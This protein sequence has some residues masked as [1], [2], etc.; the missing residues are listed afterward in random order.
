MS[1]FTGSAANPPKRM[2]RPVIWV[3]AACLLM[4][5]GANFLAAHSIDCWLR[6]NAVPEVPEYPGA[7]FTDGASRGL[8]ERQSPFIGYH[9]V[10]QAE[11]EDVMRFYE[12]KGAACTPDVQGNV[13]RGRTFPFGD[14]T[15]YVGE[16][17]DG[18]VFMG[19]DL[20]WKAC[21]QGQE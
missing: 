6:A 14:Y 13:C 18:H 7:Q 20:T 8:D 5:T 15:V 2:I 1:L 21:R 19:I 17:I 9:Y 4:A 10:A 12:S 3:L 11:P 16:A